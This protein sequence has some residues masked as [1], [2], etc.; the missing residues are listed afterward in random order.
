ML[1]RARGLGAAEHRPDA[2]CVVCGYYAKNSPPSPGAPVTAL[3]CLPLVPALLLLA[4]ACATTPK[5]DD[6]SPAM[7]PVPRVAVPLI[8]HKIA[9][10]E[11]L[12]KSQ[13]A[14]AACEK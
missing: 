2:S 6:R 1:P 8:D 5:A 11:I 9:P 13:A 4:S 12:R 10:D 7:P 14:E 3:R